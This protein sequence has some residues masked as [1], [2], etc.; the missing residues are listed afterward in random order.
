MPLAGQLSILLHAHLPYV[1][2]PEHPDFLEEDWLYE[3]IGECY[4]P[5]LAMMDRLADEGVPFRLAMTITPTLAEMLEDP[6]LIERAGQHLGRLVD[7]AERLE[8]E[9]REGP[10]AAA[11]AARARELR[12]VWMGFEAA[13]GR[14]LPRFA[15]HAEAGRLEILGCA[16]THALLPLLATDAGRRAQ[17]RAG[18]KVH[19]RHF[20]RHPAGLWLPECAWVPS[21]DGLLERARWFVLEAHGLTRAH[22]P[23]RDGVARPV[24]TPRGR[25]VFGR[26]P[27]SSEAVW[28]ARA[29]YPG[30]PAYREFYRDVGFDLPY[31]TVRPFLHGDG[32]R[33][34][35]GIRLHRV[36]GEVP[37][38]EKAPYEPALAEA[39]AELH[40]AD[41][42]AGRLRALEALGERMGRTPHLLA[43]YDAELFGH[44]WSEGPRFLEGVLR[45]LAAE[46]RVAL[47]TPS[48]LLEREPLHQEVVPEMSSWGEGGYFAV[49]LNEKN[50]WIWPHLHRA[51]ER[52]I[53]LARAFFGRGG[54]R[55]RALAQ[56]GRELL[57]A[58]SSDWPFILSMQTSPAYAERRIREHLARFH[59]I[60]APL[61]QGRVD[62]EAL[63]RSEE[64]APLFPELDG[65]E[66]LPEGELRGS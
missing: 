47:L 12:Q 44:W 58:Q 28:S 30:H 36:T 23:A 40:A 66:W 49:W 41:F 62:L 19:H 43:P 6:L 34:A 37:L 8:R 51:E 24:V 18:Q 27:G 15:A 9:L 29:G 16:A 7:L 2:H 56:A 22:P 21:M 32:V 5:L 4:L 1:R 54:E 57:L 25:A 45:R 61:E 20:G 3:A 55:G 63:R 42:V 48:E 26:D 64:Q 38:G 53:A 31:A 39:Q 33:R 46:P 35:V 11:I 59:A 13:Q 10:F 60:A 50:D 14:L 65:G 17:I 52:M